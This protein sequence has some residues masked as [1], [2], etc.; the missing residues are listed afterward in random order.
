MGGHPYRYVVDYEQ[1]LQAALDRLRADVFRRGE[2][3]GADQ[4][5]KSPEAAVRASGES[6]TRSIL[7]ITKVVAKPDYCCAAL[8]T[9]DEMLRYF[10][11]DA[12]SL[13]MA[14][15]CESFWMDLERGMAR[16]V[17]VL[18]D[19]KKRLLFAGYS[20]D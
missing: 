13:A 3:Y 9:R 18:D 2:Y 11:T 10:G 15:D 8:L 20:F 14:D 17:I 6:G 19:G 7:D 12:P 1:D 16:C 5:P 4:G